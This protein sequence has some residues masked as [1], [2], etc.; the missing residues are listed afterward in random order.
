MEYSFSVPVLYDKMAMS[1]HI[2]IAGATGCGKSVTL[3]GL[4]Y[5]AMLKGLE[6]GDG[7]RFIYFDM[8]MVELIDWRDLPTCVGYVDNPEDAP[9]NL[10][11]IVD[12]MHERYTVMQRNH[13][14]ETKEGHVYIVIDELADFIQN[15]ACHEALVTIGR[16][17]RAA[18]LHIVACTQ[19][20]SRNTLSAS[21]MQNMTCRLALKCNSPI[22]SRQ[23]VGSAGAENLPEHGRGILNMG[24]AEHVD[25]PMVDQNDINRLIVALGGKVYQQ[26]PS[27]TNSPDKYYKMNLL[28]FWDD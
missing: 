11:W 24:K 28:E 4:I 21:F 26:S 20:P 5:T 7:T 14:K 23:I 27:P 8:K 25:V 22:E 18:H 1:H 12:K 15:K 17:G 6:R 3:N 19:D 2:L 13:I 10:R 9:R 16:L